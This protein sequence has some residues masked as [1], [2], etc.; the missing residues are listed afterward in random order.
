MCTEELC[1]R[2][3]FTEIGDQVPARSRLTTR[4]RGNVAAAVTAT[5]WAMSEVAGDY[6]LA[7]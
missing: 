2:G 7:W 3:S 5:N 4:L 6:G 1:S